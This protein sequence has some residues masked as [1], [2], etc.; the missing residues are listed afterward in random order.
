[1]KRRARRTMSAPAKST[2]ATRG[3]SSN[4]RTRCF[5]RHLA[6][7]D[8]R[9]KRHFNR[10]FWLDSEAFFGEIEAF[11]ERSAK[12]FVT[13]LHIGD[14]EWHDEAGQKREKF[15]CKVRVKAVAISRFKKTR[16]VHDIS[17]AAQ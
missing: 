7:P 5:D 15:I 9:D 12:G 11:N 13:R 6:V 4:I 17:L 10:H 16:A 2:H 1:M 8:A 14:G 3:Q